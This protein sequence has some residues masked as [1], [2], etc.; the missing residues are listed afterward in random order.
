MAAVSLAFRL[1]FTLSENIMSPLD[2]LLNWYQ[3]LTPDSLCEIAQ[4]YRA[5]AHFK[6][7]FNEVRGIAPIA[8]IFT[9]MFATTENPR[10]VIDERIEQGQQAFVS[11]RFEF[12]VKGKA[13]V[14]AGGSHLVF[15]DAGLILVHRDYWDAAE[16]LFQKLPIIGGL[17]RWLR[18]R[19]SA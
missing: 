4:L 3:T 14:V 12:A 10:F 6:D 11:W 8:A 17:I 2:K 16:E 18:K 1:I 9:H 7:P 15:D 13:Y 5:D 19:F